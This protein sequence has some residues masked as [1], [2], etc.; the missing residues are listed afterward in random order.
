MVDR[1]FLAAVLDSLKQPVLVANRDHVICF[2]NE[3][4]ARYYPGGRSL[5]GTRLLD[6]HPRPES[7]DRILRI[8]AQLEAGADEVCYR[9]DGERRAFMCAVRDADGCL[10]GYYERFE[11]VRQA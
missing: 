1:D 11:P 8:F 5:L 9:E 6:C 4:A 2:L 7:R 10:I 3:A